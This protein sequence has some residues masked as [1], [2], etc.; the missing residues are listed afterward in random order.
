MTPN[1]YEAAEVKRYA[2]EIRLVEDKYRLLRAKE[3]EAKLQLIDE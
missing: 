3:E 1:A 2:A